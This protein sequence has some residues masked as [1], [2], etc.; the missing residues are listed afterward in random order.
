MIKTL[1]DKTQDA[2]NYTVNWNV[3]QEVPGLYFYRIK[4]GSFTAVKK[5]SL[6]R[7]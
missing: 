1:V 3:E 4:A 5:C 6:L 2:G 7:H